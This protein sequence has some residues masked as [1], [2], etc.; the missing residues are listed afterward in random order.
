[1]MPWV[2]TWPWRDA[3]LVHVAGLNNGQGF[4]NEN[5]GPSHRAQLPSLVDPIIPRV[6]GAS[7]QHL[8]SAIDYSRAT[9]FNRTIV[10]IPLRCEHAMIEIRHFAHRSLKHVLV[11]EIEATQSENSSWTPCTL[12]LEWNT[13][14]ITGG[15]SSASAADMIFQNLSRDNNNVATRSWTGVNRFPEESWLFLTEAAIVA[16]SVP[17]NPSLVFSAPGSVHRMIVSYATNIT[18]ETPTDQAPVEIATEAWR[19]ADAL[20][21]QSNVSSRLWQLH[22][23]AWSS[24]WASGGLEIDGNSS[25]AALIN[26]SLYDIL[27]SM[28]ADWDWSSSPGGLGTNGYNGHT[29]WD[30]ETW[31]FPVLAVLHPD[32]AR[33]AVNYRT[34][35]LNASMTRAVE[36]GYSG[37]F[38]TWESGITGLDT[39]PWREAD[40]DE[41]HISADIPLAWRRYYYVT[42]D[43]KWLASAW[44]ALYQTCRFWECRFTRTDSNASAMPPAGF[45][46]RCSSKGGVGNFT[47]RH[48]VCPDE[49]SGV[50]NDSA[51]TNA[52]A[53]QTLSW[54]IEASQLLNESVP[55]TW[56]EIASSPYLP[57]IDF[58]FPT[59]SNGL[60]HQ[61]YTG[62]EGLRYINQ[63]DVALLQYPLGLNMSADQAKR[64]LDYW[65]AV[66]N[67]NGMFT[68]DA[69]YAAAYLALGERSAADAQLNAAWSHV[70]RHFNVFMETADGTG[71]QHFITGNGGLLQNIL[72]GYAGLR[73]NR[74]GVLSFSSKRP[75]LPPLGITRV[76]LRGLHL[77]AT[78]FDLT[79][80]DTTICVTLQRSGSRRSSAVQTATPLLYLA[81]LS[82]SQAF[83]LTE[84]ELCVHNEAMEIVVRV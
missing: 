78:P 69:S 27:S 4:G 1:M 76:T 35:R 54:C 34:Q 70:E 72:F 66:T 12:D 24:L 41:N 18:G 37:A 17:P 79:Y 42:G 38:W 44:D 13:E 40:L 26:G 25:F 36:N 50:V 55:S 51:Y 19:E 80:N 6:A 45:G 30:M 22:V 63:A 33:N 64:D 58:V 14:N 73:I 32:L 21:K 11:V 16:S 3:G 74:L 59:N 28:R 9:Y 49:G 57:L 2:N 39:A 68:G 53:A 60:V 29:F 10:H 84:K 62:Y 81:V 47:V 67:F 82:T 65:S 5:D 20:A 75:L 15:G 52:A 48:V 43:R 77:F 8:G 46:P 7:Y 61:E 83:L 56:H 23:E 71:T 31:I